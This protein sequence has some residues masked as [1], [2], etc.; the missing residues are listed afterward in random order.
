MLTD[1]PDEKLQIFIDGA[2]RYIARME[3]A[4]ASDEPE[5]DP[6]LATHVMEDMRK[7]LQE[8]VVEKERRAT[9]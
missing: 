1:W 9:I 5:I 4:I 7:R 2:R 6:E 3:G 8:A